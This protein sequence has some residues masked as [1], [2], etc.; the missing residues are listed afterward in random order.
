MNSFLSPY[1]DQS[2][3]Q[4]I[5]EDARRVMAYN[6][7]Q[8]FVKLLTNSSFKIAFWCRIGTFLRHKGT[9]WKPLYCIVFL[10]HKHHQE[11]FGIQVPIGIKI[12]GGMFFPHYGS[13]V[14]N[15][16]GSYGK[17]FTAMQGCTVGT[18]RGGKHP[19]APTI[20][21][22]VLMCANSIVN[23]NIKIG[24]NVVVAAGAVVTHDI[25]DNCIVAGVPA[26]IISTDS[27]EL[28]SHYI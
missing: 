8:M 18:N 20:G 17:N 24:N 9:I 26:K 4:L 19:G 2:T 14:I 27:S 23:G 3:W 7:R 28:L 22:N 10:I 6:R 1:S 12:G 5:K 11:K 13:I 25:P 21:D 15:D 16:Y